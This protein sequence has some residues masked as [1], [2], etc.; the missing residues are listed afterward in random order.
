MQDAAACSPFGDSVSLS[1]LAVSVFRYAWIFWSCS[2]V[3]TEAGIRAAA[4][5]A[6][7]PSVHLFASEPNVLLCPLALLI[8]FVWLRGLF[9][10]SR[11]WPFAAGLFLVLGFFLSLSL[12][13][14]APMPLNEGE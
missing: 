7:V 3:T 12:L 1:R 6:L 14:L 2:S 13:P 5:S 9:G 4:A 10:G 11:A 8:C